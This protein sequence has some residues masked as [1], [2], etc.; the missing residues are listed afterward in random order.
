MSKESSVSSHRQDQLLPRRRVMRMMA[1]GAGAAS[2]ASVLAAC[3]SASAPATGGGTAIPSPR[4]TTAASSTVAASPAAAS[5]PSVPASGK[6]VVAQGPAITDLDASMHTGML[7]FNIAVHIMEP[8]FLRGEDLQ[9][10][11]LL[12]EKYEFKDDTTLLVSIREGI[13]FHDGS[14]LTSDD[15]VFTLQ[16]ASGPTSKSEHAIYMT[17]VQSVRPVDNRTTEVKLSKPDATLIGR[18]ALIPI[19]PR[20]VVEQLGDDGFNSKPMGT[21]PYTFVSWQKG[22]RVTLEAF[23]GY[24]RAPASIKQLIFRGVKEDATRVADLRT[25]ALDIATNIPTQQ[26]AEVDQS[27]NAKVMKV[28]S[29]RSVYAVLNTRQPPFNDLRM[30]QAVNYAVDKKLITEGV[31]D[32]AGSPIGEPVG[33][34]VFGYNPDLKN[35]YD[36]DLDKAKK[37]IA[38][39]GYGGGV[40]VK[41]FGP[42]GRLEKGDEVTQNIA[43]QLKRVGIRVSVNLIE[44]QTY[45][46]NYSRK[47]NPDLGLGYYSNANNTA[48]ADY[49]LSAGM[50]SKGRAPYWSS[51]DVDALIDQGKQTIDQNKRKEIYHDA[52]KKILDAAPWLFLYSQVD[53]YGVSNR[54]KGWK[55]RPDEMIYLYGLSVTG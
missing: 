23:P 17:S 21:G 33:P 27:K 14:P 50:S 42:A 10:Q 6:V 30:R 49:L 25:G 2:L 55:P 39:A 19:V 12:A 47:L 15:V 18:L 9:P 8:L 48:D 37:L 35:Y 7:A 26:I 52:V 29:L 31:L 5:N 22:D 46:E 51:P 53:N 4:A 11:P 34:E 45:L 13:K 41:L 44:F 38:D 40:D 16:R 54:L 43:D 28:N 32:G 1:A 24:W 3:G 20:K 36:Y